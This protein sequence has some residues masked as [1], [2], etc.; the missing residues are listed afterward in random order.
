MT[1]FRVAAVLLLCSIAAFAQSERGT[2][3]GSVKDASGA[4]IVGARVA[5][6]NTETNSVTN[7]TSN[8]TGDT[9]RPACR[10][11][12]TTCA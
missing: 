6:T 4:V 11:V 9:R 1:R 3:Q 2:I 5:I 8:E 7:L 12:P 10:S